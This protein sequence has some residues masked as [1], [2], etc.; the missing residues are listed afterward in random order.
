MTATADTAALAPFRVHGGRVAAARARFGGGDDWIDLSTGIAPWA[1]PVPS[2]AA[3]LASL[4]EPCALSALEDA[5]AEAFDMPIGMTTMAVPGT[6]LAMR[7]LAR[8]LPARSV[9]VVRPG[10]DG[11]AAAW[12]A[13]T[14]VGFDALEDAVRDHDLLVFASPANPGGETVAADRLRAL[15]RQATVVLDAAYADPLPIDPAVD[16]TRTIV[17]RSF[18]KFYGL[19]GLRLGFVVAPPDVASDLRELLG[20]WPVSGPAIAIGTAAYRDGAWGDAQSRRIAEAGNRLDAALDAAD[21]DIVGSTPL[22]RLVRSDQATRLFLTLAHYRILTRPFTHTPDRLRIG[23]PA[24]P[25]A[26]ARLS[27]ALEEFR[28]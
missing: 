11:H 22:F 10:Y 2:T 24:G 4:P 13:A 16:V 1:W 12:P 15:T 23:L 14:P 26:V 3:S 19:P 7:L 25:A 18:G 5:A 9:G 20:D 21:L 27:A 6:D 8:I 17:L 28:R